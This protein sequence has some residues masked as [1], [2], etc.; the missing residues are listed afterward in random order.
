MPKLKFCDSLIKFASYKM[1]NIREG[2]SNAQL[3]NTLLKIWEL[4]KQ[5]FVNIYAKNIHHCFSSLWVQNY[6][7]ISKCM[8]LKLK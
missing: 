4:K 7:F 3:T 8:L 2:N 6:V 5:I 1:W